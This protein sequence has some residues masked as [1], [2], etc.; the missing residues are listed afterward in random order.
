LN[1]TNNTN[2]KIPLDYN[3]PKGSEKELK[4][5][6]IKARASLNEHQSYRV[7]FLEADKPRS[8]P[9]H[10]YYRMILSMF[11]KDTGNDQKEIHELMKKQFAFT[12]VQLN[13]TSFESNV[14]TTTMNTKEMTEFIDK[15]RLWL[16][17]EHQYKT[18]DPNRIPDEEYA[19]I[20]ARY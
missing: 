18:P 5:L 16:L 8:L 7:I 11:C 9:Q 13:G 2:K 10:K 14:S 19:Q 3:L 20:I 1:Q 12:I 4:K 6:L 17:E 15:F